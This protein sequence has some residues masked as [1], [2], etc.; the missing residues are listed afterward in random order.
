[1]EASKKRD[2]WEKPNGAN[3]DDCHFMV[4]CMESWF[5]ADWEAVSKFFGQGFKI[6]ERPVQNIEK[7]DKDAIFS[8]LKSA[9]RNC[10]SKQYDKGRH[11]FKLLSSISAKRVLDAS[12]WAKRLV[13]EIKKRTS[14]K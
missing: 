7:I 14:E 6:N 2:N 8:V 4:Q 10:R 11:S 5:F 13:D 9:S 1:M 3:N 12:P